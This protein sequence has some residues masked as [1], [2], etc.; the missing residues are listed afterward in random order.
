MKR[1]IHRRKESYLLLLSIFRDAEFFLA[2][3]GDV[4]P[5]SGGGYYG[6][7]DQVGV[8]LQTF[9]VLRLVL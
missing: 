7:G 3:I 2:Q 9:D 4:N 1:R 5:V 8:G 6:D